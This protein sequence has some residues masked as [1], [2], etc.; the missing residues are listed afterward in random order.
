MLI[1]QLFM[2]SPIAVIF[3]IF[4]TTGVSHSFNVIDGLPGCMD[5]LYLEYNPLAIA[6]DPN[7]CLTLKEEGCINSSY[8]ISMQ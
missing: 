8:M 2:I 1:D 7:L 3:T 5:S 6:E 4:A